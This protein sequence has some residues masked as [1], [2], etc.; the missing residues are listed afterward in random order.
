MLILQYYDAAGHAHDLPL[1][2][3]HETAAD[4]TTTI[5]IYD[6]CNSLPEQGPVSRQIAHFDGLTKLLQASGHWVILA[7][8]PESYAWF[9]NNGT[10]FTAAFEEAAC[11]ESS[12]E[13]FF[14]DLEDRMQRFYRQYSKPYRGSVLAIYHNGKKVFLFSLKFISNPKV[15]LQERLS[16][17]DLIRMDAAA[18]SQ[19]AHA[20]QQAMQS[21]IDSLTQT[22]SQ[23]IAAFFVR[24]QQSTD[25]SPAAH[26]D[27][28]GAS[29]E[30]AE[31]VID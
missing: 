15:P 9:T 11:I 2:R 26:L 21:S 31:D 12:L 1:T 22:L 18:R 6:C 14:Q 8:K 25:P 3:L 5:V 16:V 7:A 30:A 20:S 19:Q 28:V 23:S 17:H 4:R 27:S 29:S 10:L 24:G 13:N